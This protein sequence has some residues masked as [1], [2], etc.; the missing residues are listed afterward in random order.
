MYGYGTSKE[1]SGMKTVLTPDEVGKVLGLS[2]RTI[3][4]WLES[5]KLSGIKVGNRWRVKEEDLDKFVDEPNMYFTDYVHRAR[6]VELQRLSHAKA[7]ELVSCIYILGCLSKPLD[8]FVSERE[9]DIQ[10]IVRATRFWGPTEKALVRA[11]LAL[12]DPREAADIN[13]VFSNLDQK[14]NQVMMQALRLRW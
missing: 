3:V 9:V 4:G 14:G 11:A 10:G 2:R 5:G 12:Y 13:E 1:D 7:R 6:F 8:G